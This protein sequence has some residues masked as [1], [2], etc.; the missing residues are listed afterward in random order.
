MMFQG[1]IVAMLLLVGTAPFGAAQ[2]ICKSETNIF[3]VKVDLFASELGTFLRINQY[4]LLYLHF[5]AD[6][7]LD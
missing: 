6:Q 2:E 5:S 7:N 1:R 3:T 4:H